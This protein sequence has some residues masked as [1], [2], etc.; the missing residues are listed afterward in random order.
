MD[1]VPVRSCQIT[2]SEFHKKS[3]VTI[4]GIASAHKL[5]AVQAGW[6][7]K[8]A[9]VDQAALIKRH[10]GREAV[11]SKGSYGPTPA[12]GEKIVFIEHPE[13]IR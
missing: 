3:I 13:E 6:V 4:E 5:H 8:Q 10:G 2:A 12:P 1:G 7:E 11:L 9:K